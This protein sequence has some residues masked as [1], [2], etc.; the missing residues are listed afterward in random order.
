M[1]YT[2]YG[3]YEQVVFK[4]AKAILFFEVG[5]NGQEHGLHLGSEG[6]V[7]GAQLLDIQYGL[8]FESLGKA[9]IMFKKKIV[10]YNDKSDLKLIL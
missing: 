9:L 10:G 3:L 6:G 2:Q 4:I 5:R 8:P 7:L 1:K